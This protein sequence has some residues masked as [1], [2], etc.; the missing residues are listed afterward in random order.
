[1][2]IIWKSVLTSEFVSGLDPENL[3]YLIRDLDKAVEEVCGE[4]GVF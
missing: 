1:M 4:W 2:E 3:P